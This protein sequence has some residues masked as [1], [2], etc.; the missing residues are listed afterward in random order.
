[1]FR[2]S[3]LLHK[4]D[5]SLTNE[6]MKFNIP[7]IT[8][9]LDVQDGDLRREESFIRVLGDNY[10][11]KTVKKAE[12]SDD[13]ILRIVETS[14][15]GSWCSVVFNKQI[16]KVSETDL[17]EEPIKE[18][19]HLFVSFDFYSKPFEIKTFRIRLL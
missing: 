7:M 11:L 12:N 14:G 6:G 18:L 13:L 2:Y 4:N 1:V 3:L 16:D 19:E 10:T 9:I 5:I 8:E 15:K 17:F